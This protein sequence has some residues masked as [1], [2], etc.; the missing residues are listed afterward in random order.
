MIPT[1]KVFAISFGW[2]DELKVNC[3]VEV[4]PPGV[5]E[6]YYIFLESSKPLIVAIPRIVQRSAY[7]VLKRNYVQF[8]RTV[9]LTI[10]TAEMSFKHSVL[11]PSTIIIFVW[12]PKQQVDDTVQRNKCFFL[13][14]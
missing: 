6:V 7:C 14:P 2:T 8:G 11:H 13:S 9:N 4:S 1:Y 10:V 5:Q 12:Q 3:V